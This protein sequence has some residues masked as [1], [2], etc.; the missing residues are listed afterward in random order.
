MVKLG[1][2]GKRGKH[3]LETPIHPLCGSATTLYSFAMRGP[4][5]GILLAFTLGAMAPGCGGGSDRPLIARDATGQPDVARLIEQ[6]DSDDPVDRMAA[7]GALHQVAGTDR[8][9]DPT[10]PLPSREA[11]IARWVDWY[12]EGMPRG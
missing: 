4:D 7:I 9:Y 10:A 2:G 1:N 11:A 8:G 6:L 5:A 12:Q 3:T